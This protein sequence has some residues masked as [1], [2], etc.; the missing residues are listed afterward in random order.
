[1]FKV[2]YCHITGNDV[3]QEFNTLLEAAES[4]EYL[5]IEGAEVTLL[6]E[7]NSEIHLPLEHSI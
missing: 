1:M 4:A 6:D 7:D 5:W 3:T 2:N